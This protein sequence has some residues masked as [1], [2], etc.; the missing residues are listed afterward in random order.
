[1]E[2]K[3]GGDILQIEITIL[4]AI[5]GCFVTLAGWL[6]SR[7]KK[8]SNDSEWRGTV[9][10]TLHDIDTKLDGIKDDFNGFKKQLENHERRITKIETKIEGE[11]HVQDDH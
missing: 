11:H 10:T 3:Q 6:A 7:E 8:I 1:M 9:N 5:I 4:I 2:I